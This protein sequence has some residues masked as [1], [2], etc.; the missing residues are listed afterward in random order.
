MNIEQ[1]EKFVGNILQVELREG[2]E[3][4]IYKYAAVLSSENHPK[5][6]LVSHCTK[7][8]DEAVAAGFD[9]LFEEHAKVW[10]H[11]WEECDITIEGDVAA[12]QGIRFNIFQ[13]TQTYTGEDKRL[14][15]GPKG[16]TGEK[17]GGST[18]WDTEAYCIPFYLGTAEQK[19]ARNLL[20]YRYKHLDKAIEN[21]K[22]LGFKDGAAFYPFVTMNGE[23]CHNEWE[24]TFEE[25]HRTSAI[26]MLFA[27]MSTIQ[28]IKLTLA[29]VDWRY[30][31]ASQ[32]FG[33]NVLIGQRIEISMLSWA[34]QVQTNMR[35]MSTITGTPITW[36][37]GH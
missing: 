14:N 5:D 13:L 11:K 1:R 15:I 23:E 28:A 12:Q 32:D 29:N 30:S 9:A 31:L 33:R 35:T 22:K 19:V 21:A 36:V 10:A 25:I 2:K 18:Y 17:Y 34:L 26:A 20:I 7:V 6:K 3:I 8:L 16:F 24:I 4:V 37:C 27:T